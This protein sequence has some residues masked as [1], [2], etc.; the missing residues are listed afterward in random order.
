MDRCIAAA[1]GVLHVWGWFWSTLAYFVASANSMNG[2]PMP[3]QGLGSTH[4]VVACMKGKIAP[5]RPVP[6]VALDVLVC[7]PV[8]EDGEGLSP[9]QMQCRCCSLR[10]TGSGTA[11]PFCSCCVWLARGVA[12]LSCQQCKKLMVGLY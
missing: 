12:V 11:V 5:L 3:L 2:M 6:L 4:N 7:S 8:F 1:C 10:C 9:Q